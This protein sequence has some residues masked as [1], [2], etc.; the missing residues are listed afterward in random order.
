MCFHK[1]EVFLISSKKTSEEIERA[2]EATSPNVHLVAHR[3]GLGIGAN[4]WWLLA[5]PEIKTRLQFLPDPCVKDEGK[6]IAQ[7]TR[8][9]KIG[10]RLLRPAR[11]KV[12]RYSDKAIRAIE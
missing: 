8:G 11:V 12:G 4:K 6:V 2:C 1:G 9:Y 3:V 10:D 5:F 7:H